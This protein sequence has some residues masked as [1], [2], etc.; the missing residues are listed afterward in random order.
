MKVG[1]LSSKRDLSDVRDIVSGYQLL[2]KKGKTG[3][4]Y[5]ICSGK[6]YSIK[7]LLK[8]L[9]SL[10]KKKIRVGMDEK[11]T[12]PAEIPVLVG[13]NSKI[14]RETSWKPKISIEKTLQDTLN[15]WRKK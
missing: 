5:N 6:A 8:F 12:R 13:D 11:R 15:F 7:N 9:I 14:K 10:S 4:A 3:E 2:M 1:N